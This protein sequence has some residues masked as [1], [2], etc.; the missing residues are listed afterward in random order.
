MW[1]MFTIRMEELLRI[2]IVGWTVI[3]VAKT[4][5]NT[6][7]LKKHLFVCQVYFY[8]YSVCPIVSSVSDF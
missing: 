6:K 8:F 7:P 2:L 1:Q 3:E 4:G 5:K